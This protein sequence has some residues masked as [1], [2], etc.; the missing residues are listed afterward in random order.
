M[1]GEKKERPLPWEEPRVLGNISER[2]SRRQAVWT[3][4]FLLSIT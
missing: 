2:P 1:R 4:S 3:F